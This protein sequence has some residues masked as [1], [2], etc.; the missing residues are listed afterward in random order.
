MSNCAC[1][2]SVTGEDESTGKTTQPVGNVGSFAYTGSVTVTIDQE[3]DGRCYN[4]ESCPNIATACKADFTVSATITGA[5]PGDP[6]P[7]HMRFG[8]NSY[9]LTGTG[10]PPTYPYTGT[11]LR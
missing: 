6:I 8:G 5:F 10:S 1:E 2:F 3:Y 4:G 11:I 9:G 7:D